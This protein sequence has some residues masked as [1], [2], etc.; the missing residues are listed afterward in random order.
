LLSAA[1]AGPV[2]NAD[3]APASI[4]VRVSDFIPFLP[5]PVFVRRRAAKA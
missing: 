3:S 1:Q 4:N 5:I 2:A